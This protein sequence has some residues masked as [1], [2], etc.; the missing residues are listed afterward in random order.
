MM[1]EARVF[2]VVAFFGYWGWG[3]VVYYVLSFFFLGGFTNLTLRVKLAKMG[4][5]IMKGL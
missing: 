1:M 5:W 2:R 3:F 4:F